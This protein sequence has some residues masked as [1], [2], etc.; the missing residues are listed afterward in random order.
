MPRCVPRRSGLGKRRVHLRSV[1]DPSCV[2]GDRKLEPP[3]SW[4]R[5][6][7]TPCQPVTVGG[8]DTGPKSFQRPTRGILAETVCDVPRVPSS[9]FIPRLVRGGLDERDPLLDNVGL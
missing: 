5:K 3:R 8:V 1:A 9:L 2:N 6:E 7:D 4:P